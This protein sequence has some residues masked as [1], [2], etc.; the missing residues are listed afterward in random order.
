LKD[1]GIK[2]IVVV[3]SGEE[4]MKLLGA[5]DKYGTFDLVLCDWNMSGMSGLD[6][7]R[8]VRSRDPHIPFL[9]ITGNSDP[10][11]VVEAKK[12]GVTG[13]IAKPFAPATLHKKVSVV[14]QM[15]AKR[16]EMAGAN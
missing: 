6:L 3:S 14:A 7:L 5:P 15:L 4:A 11:F 1:F 8:Q 13:Y 9:M 16:R 12:H 10:D 2:K